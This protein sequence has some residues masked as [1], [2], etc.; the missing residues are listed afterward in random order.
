MIQSSKK[1]LWQKQESIIQGLAGS[2]GFLLSA[3]E[4][5]EVFSKWDK[6]T[7]KL[8]KRPFLLSCGR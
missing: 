1:E 2:V 8:G 7:Q 5:T 4:S 6:M 3:S